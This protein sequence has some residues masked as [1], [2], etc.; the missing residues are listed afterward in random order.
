MLRKHFTGFEANLIVVHAKIGRMRMR[1]I[2]R[3]QRDAS[4]GNN[5]SNCRSHLLLN[6]EFN[7]QVHTFRN[8]FLSIADRRIGIVAVSAARDRAVG[9]VQCLADDQARGEVGRRRIEREGLDRLW[10]P[11]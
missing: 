8:K 4:L 10:P 2:D 6:L 7:D 5:V 11:L 9:E 1:N 3:D